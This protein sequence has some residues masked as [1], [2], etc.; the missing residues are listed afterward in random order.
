MRLSMIAGLL[1]LALQGCAAPADS[2]TPGL[3]CSPHAAFDQWKADPG[4]VNLLD[5][6][7]PE[8]YIFIGHAPMARNIPV[9]FLANKWD[10]KEKKPVFKPNPDFVADCRKHYQSEDKIILMC[11]TGKRSPDAVKLLKEAGYKDVLL[12]EGGFDGERGKDCFDHGAGTLVKPGWKNGNMIWT[13]AIN[14]EMLYLK[15]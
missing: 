1:A 14:P 12:V 10:A 8:E 15:D 4:K 2:G 7:T 13:Y 9:K 3:S 6:R 5:V 11:S